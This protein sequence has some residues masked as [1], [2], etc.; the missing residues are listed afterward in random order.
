MLLLVFML[1][2]NT[3]ERQ[4]RIL[5][6]DNKPNR[7]DAANTILTG[8][9]YNVDIAENASQAIAKTQ[10]TTY[11]LMLISA[12]LTDLPAQKLLTRIYETIPKIKKII[13][14]DQAHVQDAEFLVKHGADAN[15]IEPLNQKT[16]LDTVETQLLNRDD[17]AEE[18]GSCTNVL[19]IGA[20]PDDI[21]LGCGGTLIKHVQSGDNVYAMIFT[22]GEKGMAETTKIDRQ[23]ESL[24]AL[25]LAGVNP[26]NIYFM[27][28][29]DTEL[30]QVRQEVMNSI[31][32]FCTTFKVQLIYTHSN[33]AQHQDHVTI[34]DE[35]MRA[36]RK[37]W[38]I[39][40][41]ESHGATNPSF[42]PNLFVDITDVMSE[43][44]LMLNCHQSQ[45]AKNYLR[46]DSVVALAQF[47]SSQSEEF[48]Y[49]EAFEIIKMN[50]GKSMNQDVS[51]RDIFKM[52]LQNSVAS[53]E[54]ALP[55]LDANQPVM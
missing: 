17:A 20:H 25:T 49:A 2:N 1:S 23:Q 7:R 38:G 29:P 6:V 33:K 14:T 30:W 15:L 43:K 11:Q 51:I 3:S 52:A 22:N 50:L 55:V 42:S 35:T 44:I 32:K 8:A 16:L 28:Y 31:A 24:K 54:Q 12:N 41:Y 46:V 10:Q 45:I 18:T 40:A 21:E 36:A 27:Q 19:F 13:L 48:H 39:M 4:V 5:L 26:L 34:F 37:A 9:G 47:R 53:K